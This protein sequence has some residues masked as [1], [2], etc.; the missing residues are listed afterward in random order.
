MPQFIQLFVQSGALVDRVEPAG[1]GADGS[2]LQLGVY[3]EAVLL[4]FVEDV[5]VQLVRNGHKVPKPFHQFTAPQQPMRVPASPGHFHHLVLQ[6]AAVLGRA[7]ACRAFL[8]GFHRTCSVRVR[9]S[10]FRHVY[11]SFEWPLVK[12]CQVSPHSKA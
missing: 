1:F 2:V 5:R 8:C 11:P 7:G 10:G 3:S 9:L 6:T 4:G 12:T